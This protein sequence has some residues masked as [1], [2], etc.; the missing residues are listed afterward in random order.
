MN[1]TSLTL[2]IPL[3]LLATVVTTP[4][5]ITDD[6]FAR[7]GHG[8]HSGGDLIQAVSVSNSCLNPV[9]NSNT[10]DNMIS[11]GNCGG[12]ISQQGKSGQ[13]STPTTIQNANPIIEVQLS[14]TTQPPVTGT[15]PETCKECFDILNST[16]Q[17][18]FERILVLEKPLGPQWGT[19][20]DSITTIEELCNVWA[21]LNPE[22]RVI[23]IRDIQNILVEM[24]VNAT[25]QADINNCLI[26]S[27]G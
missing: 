22:Q 18:A 24:R 8:K 7:N 21:T 13:A 3:I 19:N 26:P 10:N 6:A 12:T 9:S 14:T 20:A 11:N 15:P 1:R 25:T 17:A 5:A 27:V 16:Q 2:V 23:A 4:V